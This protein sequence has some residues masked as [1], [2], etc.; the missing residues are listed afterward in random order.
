MTPIAPA[1]DHG[2]RF[3]NLEEGCRK[4][5]AETTLEG[6]RSVLEAEMLNAFAMPTRRAKFQRD[7]ERATS[8]SKLDKL[9]ADLVLLESG[10]RVI[11]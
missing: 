6:K 4:V 1:V 10:D 9:A 5:W 7:I 3:N 8:M 2:R 11:K